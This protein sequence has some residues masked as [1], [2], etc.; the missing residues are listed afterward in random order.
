[1]IV[2]SVSFTVWHILYQYYKF[3]F[4]ISNISII[5]QHTQSHP[6]LLKAHQLALSGF[7]HII[8]GML[9]FQIKS[10]QEITKVINYKNMLLTLL[11]KLKPYVIF[12]FL[13][14]SFNICLISALVYG[15]IAKSI[16][17]AVKQKNYYAFVRKIDSF[18]IISYLDYFSF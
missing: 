17:L 16:T 7:P 13:L 6:T 18:Y 15:K 3:L 5:T 2:V 9:W 4:R 12:S 1:M 8:F 14:N 11:Y 10:I